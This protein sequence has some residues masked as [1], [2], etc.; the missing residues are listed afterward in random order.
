M[1]FFSP[2]PR[3][4]MYT[5]PI[6]YITAFAACIRKKTM[7][8]SYRKELEQKI[9]TQ[10]DVECVCTPQ[11][12]VAIYAAIKAAV[13]EGKEVIISPNTIADVINMVICA[14]AKPIF[15]DID[16]RT[17][18]LDPNLVSEL[19]TENTAAIMVTH[20]YG[21][22]AP[23]GE[24]QAIASKH[25][26]LLIEDAAQAFGA[27]QN[28]K[29]A[30]C[31]GDIGIYSFG[32]A[33]NITGFA[34]GMLLTRHANIAARAREILQSFPEPTVPQ[35]AK[36]IIACFIKEVASC[37]L[38]F[39]HLVFPIFKFAYAK[40]IAAITKF[41]ETELDLSLKTELPK[42][43]QTQL[44]ELQAKII[45]SHLQYVTKDYEHRIALSTQY[46]EGLESISQVRTPPIHVDGNH[47]Y[48]YYPIQTD[49]RIALRSYLL[50]KNR[51]IALQHIKNTADLPAFKAFHRDCPVARKWANETIML[52]NYG[53]YRASETAKNIET[54]Q[55]FFA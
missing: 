23:M 27:T 20:L 49:N 15:C 18:N 16:P 42:S 44:S 53:K 47:V 33:K 13:P 34:G 2:Q 37:N 31:I 36:K 52:P 43:Y 41:I 21:L 17:G 46:K 40:K 55:R 38:F 32:M 19:I 3:F 26:L 22:V 14:G 24:L 51:D 45:L 4:K 10:H 5:K 25:D 6:D 39:P 12:R 30:G 8:G 1:S 54:I 48:N 7:H 29:A 9:G 35:T 50:E 11:G 28:G